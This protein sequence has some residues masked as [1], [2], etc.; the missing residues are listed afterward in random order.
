[1]S[2]RGRKGE[3]REREE[4]GREREEMKWR[5]RGGGRKKQRKFP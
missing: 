5:E 4:I 3:K 1:M 2:G